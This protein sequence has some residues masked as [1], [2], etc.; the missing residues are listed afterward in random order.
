M[1]GY[2]DDL[3]AAHERIAALQ[4]ESD[5][6]R[7]RS[8]EEGV[9]ASA[10]IEQLE[11]QVAMLER[12]DAAR[13]L[14]ERLER[15][16]AG[17]SRREAEHK[18]EL[19][20]CTMKILALEEAA[21]ERTKD[22]DR[23]FERIGQ[24]EGELAKANQNKPELDAATMKILALEE[25]VREAGKAE[26]EGLKSE[27]DEV[28]EKLAKEKKELARVERE[29]DG[30]AEALSW[31]DKEIAQLRERIALQATALRESHEKIVALTEAQRQREARPDPEPEEPVAAIQLIPQIDDDL[32]RLSP[33]GKWEVVY[34]V[35]KAMRLR[36][37]HRIAIGGML[38]IVVGLVLG[39]QAAPLAASAALIV[40]A[41]SVA[42][43][44]LTGTTVHQGTVESLHDEGAG[45]G[46]VARING[47]EVR[48]PR[49]AESAIALG[50][51]AVV[52][53]GRLGEGTLVVLTPA[54]PQP[55][56]SAGF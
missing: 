39:L 22:Y 11:R 33:A 40:G 56:T 13:A 43:S 34:R 28:R 25:S 4:R 10:R 50:K 32:A 9:A 1:S 45:G 29:V 51:H 18:A 37:R 36:R 55:P 23:A 31:K 42:F 17:A 2:R 38:V 19:D 47:S 6:I 52:E 30:D 44:M 3:R 5:D 49:A 24:L 20:A 26:I 14:R 7:K 16:E 21:Y 8:K 12:D 41:L 48:L 54:D 27:L 46:V 53:R 15:V 35:P